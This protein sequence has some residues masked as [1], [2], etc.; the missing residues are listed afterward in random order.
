MFTEC[1]TLLNFPWW[2]T[3]RLLIFIIQK[4]CYTGNLPLA[5]NKELQSLEAII[6]EWQIL[7]GG[8]K[9][10]EVNHIV[11]IHPL[12]VLHYCI[13]RFKAM[14]EITYK[15]SSARQ[16]LEG[17]EMNWGEPRTYW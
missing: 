14:S 5:T 12:F 11:V 13:A 16:I 17:V 8:W 9:W 10:I 2:P 3:I 1:A 4:L 7:E 15:V 6:I